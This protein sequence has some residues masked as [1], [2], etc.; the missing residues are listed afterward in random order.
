MKTS[1]AKEE[2]L[3]EINLFKRIVWIT[4]SKAFL[5]SMYTAPVTWPLFSAIRICSVNKSNA[6]VVDPSG[7]KPCW[8][9]LSRLLSSRYLIETDNTMLFQVTYRKCRKN[10]NWPVIRNTSWV[11]RFEYWNNLS[12]F[13]DVRKFM[14]PNTQMN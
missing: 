13:P 7:L 11:L 9:S 4:V 12:S 6:D 10:W 2:R 8:L 14:E 3:K 5:K 1:I